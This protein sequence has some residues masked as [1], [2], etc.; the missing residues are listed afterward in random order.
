MIT[1]DID[2]KPDIIRNVLI[3]SDSK[4]I[5]MGLADGLLGLSLYHYYY[6]KYTNNE[7]YINDVITYLEK[8]IEGIGD[9]YKGISIINDIIDLGDYLHFLC[10]EKLLDKE[11]INGLLID[12]DN[13]IKGFLS[14]EIEKR[15]LDPMFGA[16]KA[17]Y[18]FLNRL[19]YTDVNT[20]LQEV[21]KAIDDQAIKVENFTYW[22]ST[23]K[24]PDEPLVELGTS[25]GVAGIVNFLLQAYSKNIA[26][27]NLKQLILRGLNFL[28][29]FN[30]KKGTNWFRLEANIE[31]KLPYQDLAYGDIGIG[32]TFLNAGQVLEN[33]DLLDIGKTILEN[34]ATYRDDSGQLT[35]DASL[36]YGSSGLC[37][38]FESINKTLESTKLEQAAVYWENRTLSFDDKASDWAGYLSN[39]NA[40]FDYTHLSFM[41]GICGIGIMLMAR[42]K[43]LRH[44]Y[45]R[46]LNLY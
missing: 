4:F 38:L 29:E 18:Y 20:E 16:V 12:S 33:N 8:S 43:E 19:E 35:K 11:D 6:Y 31:E 22:E 21:L 2:L 39:Y 30:D 26:Y 37:A 44:D 9:H 46:F 34:A 15:N 3:K 1:K 45:L 36:F 13:I 17:G 25:H 7:V 10:Q 40:K 32:Y 27:K 24:D 28:Y 5:N 23:L 41:Q 42:K 14:E